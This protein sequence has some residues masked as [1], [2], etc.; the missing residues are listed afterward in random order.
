M[1]NPVRFALSAYM[2]LKQFPQNT[3]RLGPK[4]EFHAKG[5]HN[6]RSFQVGS[7]LRESIPNG[8]CFASALKSDLNPTPCYLNPIYPSRAQE[9]P[10]QKDP[11][12]NHHM[13]IMAETVFRLCQSL[14]NPQ[15]PLT[16]IVSMSCSMLFS[17]AFPL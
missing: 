4:L 2:I 5:D 16:I 15:K 7:P 3:M 1:K 6:L 12:S 13:V 10:L 11:Q 9:T 14:I 17:L 8:P